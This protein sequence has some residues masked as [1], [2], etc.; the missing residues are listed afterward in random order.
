MGIGAV[1]M[2]LLDLA[3][4]AVPELASG[5]DEAKALVNGSTIRQV[6]H[7]GDILEYFNIELEGCS[8]ITVNG[9]LVETFNPA[10]ALARELFDNFAEYVELYPGREYERYTPIAPRVTNRPPLKAWLQAILRPPPE[11]RFAGRA[12]AGTLGE[13]V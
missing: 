13:L 8:L 12:G 7:P 11:V 4:G 9:V 2:D 3:L 6:D 1:G 5:P 10:H